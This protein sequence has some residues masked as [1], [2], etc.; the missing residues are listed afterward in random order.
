MIAAAMALAMVSQAPAHGCG[1]VHGRMAVW[2]GAPSVRISII[3]SKRILG[4][5]QQ[6]ET[7]A[8]LP[9]VIRQAWAPDGQ[10]P[11]D[12][13]A[14]VGDFRVCAVTASRPGRMQLVRVVGGRA[15]V[16]RGP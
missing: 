9:A 10:G 5:V 13:V 1:M 7:F 6:D 4:V 2:N 16:R 12:G 14:L 11:Q 8:A 3:G 15:L